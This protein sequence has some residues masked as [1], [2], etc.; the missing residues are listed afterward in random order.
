MHKDNSVF[1]VRFK[2]KQGKKIGT[3]ERIDGY[4]YFITNANQFCCWNEYL[5]EAIAKELR[6]INKELNYSLEQYFN[7]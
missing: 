6:I 4:Y 1:E 5:L 2:T 3:I 7:K